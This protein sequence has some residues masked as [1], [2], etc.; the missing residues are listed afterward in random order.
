MES[1]YLFDWQI[2]TRWIVRVGEVHN[3]GPVCDACQDCINISTT[4]GFLCH[5]RHTASGNCGNTVNQKT[6]LGENRLIT[7]RKKGGC[8]HCKDFVRTVA[9]DYVVWVQAMYGGD[10][11]PQGHG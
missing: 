7:I 11:F 5:H 4:I 2:G 9:A 3:S 6:M 8:K 1:L 10:F